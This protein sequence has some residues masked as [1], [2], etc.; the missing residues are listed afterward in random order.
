MQQLLMNLCVNALQAMGGG[1]RL[2]VATRKETNCILLSVSDTGPGIDPSI[3][4]RVFD[5]FFTT[6]DVGDGTGLG[7]SVCHR[8]VEDHGGRIDAANQPG[9][10]T[11]FRVR[12]PLAPREASHEQ[13][14]A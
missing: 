6:K 9:G 12:L 1:G 11:V 10:G 14:A 2:T 13:P 4:D 8:I 5:P 7:L 3:L